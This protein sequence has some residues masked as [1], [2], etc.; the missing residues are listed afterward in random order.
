MLLDFNSQADAIKA[1]KR[2][3][4]IMGRAGQQVVQTKFASALRRSNNVSFR[5][6]ELS[7]LSGQ[8]VTLRVTKSGDLCAVLLNGN[9]IPVEMSDDLAVLVGNIAE[10]AEA[11]EQTFQAD[12]DRLKAELPKSITTSIPGMCEALERRAEY[13]DGE[14][15]ARQAAL[16]ELKALRGEPVLDEVKTVITQDSPTPEALAAATA[17][18]ESLAIVK[19]DDV[20]SVVSLPRLPG[21]D[22]PNPVTITTDGAI[23]P[24]DTSANAEVVATEQAVV[25]EIEGGFLDV[26]EVGDKSP[27]SGAKEIMDATEAPPGLTGAEI[28]KVAI[29]DDTKSTVDL[30]KSP[31]SD[32]PLQVE[33]DT[34]GMVKPV[35]VA[36]DKPNEVLDDVDPVAVPKP[37][38]GQTTD[39][40][41][42]QPHKDAGAS[43]MPNPSTGSDGPGDT[44]Q[45]RNT[46]P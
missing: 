34:N 5:E 44:N 11:N 3:A 10:A 6:A 12:Q 22:E 23:A 16:G 45:L 30:P 13:L 18:D 14:I 7:L 29:V 21:S 43:E 39:D 32:D 20:K 38:E 40:T 15:A 35:T 36:D 4:S 31:E 9:T 46:I 17:A 37:A 26:D 1:I 33:I 19:K 8:T 24:A 25:L 42:E 41:V 27:V 2:V 28:D